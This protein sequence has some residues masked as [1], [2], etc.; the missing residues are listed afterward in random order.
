MWFRKGGE[1]IR[2]QREMVS[3]GD[4]S[5]LDEFIDHPVEDAVCVGSCV[6]GEIA[7]RVLEDFA[8]NPTVLSGA[9]QWRPSS[10][11]NYPLEG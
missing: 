8:R 6:S 9:V 7:A 5:R 2:D 10:T 4:A 3:V 11:L 1:A